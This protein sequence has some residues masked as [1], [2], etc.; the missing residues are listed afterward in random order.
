M[1]EISINGHPAN[2]GL[3]SAPTR[4][5]H[6]AT[7]SPN[8]RGFQNSSYRRIPQTRPGFTQPRFPVTSSK[9][10]QWFPVSPEFILHVSCPS[11]ALLRCFVAFLS[12]SFALRLPSH[13]RVALP[14]VFLPGTSSMPSGPS[15]QTH[16]Y[17]HRRYTD[18]CTS[19]PPPQQDA[20][21]PSLRN[22]SIPTVLARQ[23]TSPQV[24]THNRLY[25]RL[26]WAGAKRTVQMSWSPQTWNLKPWRPGAKL[27][28]AIHEMFDHT[29]AHT[30]VDTVE[31]STHGQ[32]GHGVPACSVCS[33]SR[34]PSVRCVPGHGVPVCLVFS[35]S[36]NT[37]PALVGRQSRSQCRQ[38]L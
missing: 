5:L 16:S 2:T 18:I 19:P 12:L 36:V 20:G 3:D 32:S 25:Q 14:N 33:R 28:L 37:A 21:P 11:P 34:S 27:I 26:T 4:K 38:S 31:I 17:T 23:S 35:P 10:F 7:C 15:N 8:L 1:R 29:H 22:P 30:N 13:T 6:P 9:P 24:R